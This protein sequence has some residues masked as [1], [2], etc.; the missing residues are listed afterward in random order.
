MPHSA[1]RVLALNIDEVIGRDE[2]EDPIYTARLSLI[3]LDGYRS[4]DEI[5]PLNRLFDYQ[6]KTSDLP[7]RG[8]RNYGQDNVGSDNNAFR[9]EDKTIPDLSQPVILNEAN[10]IKVEVEVGDSDNE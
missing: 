2:K 1:G 6:E 4:E 3:I 5:E 8:N 9:L 10:I 7:T